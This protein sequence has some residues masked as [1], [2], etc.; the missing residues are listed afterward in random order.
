MNSPL[1]SK[2][3]ND[4][5]EGIDT[6]SQIRIQK[7]QKKG[8]QPA[9]IY[10]SSSSS[11]TFL[12][13]Q[14]QQ[15][16]NEDHKTFSWTKDLFSGPN[17]LV[18]EKSL[19]LEFRWQIWLREFSLHML[20]PFTLPVYIYEMMHARKHLIFKEPWNHLVAQPLVWVV[21]IWFIVER[22]QLEHDG[23]TAV[24]VASVFLCVLFHRAC[25]S[26]K[27]AFLTPEEYKEFHDAEV[28]ISDV[29]LKNMQI[30]S[31]WI[32][33]EVGIVLHEVWVA[34]RQLN[35]DLTSLCFHIHP[36]D[37]KDFA[38]YVD[39]AKSKLDEITHLQISGDM[40]VKIPLVQVAT[41]AYMNAN[42]PCTV[43][44]LLRTASCL[45]FLRAILFGAMRLG[46]NYKYSVLGDS[47]SSAIVSVICAYVI[48][49]FYRLLLLFVY[50][51]VVDTYRRLGVVCDVGDFIRISYEKRISHPRIQLTIIENIS[52]WVGLRRVVLRAGH[53]YRKR[54]ALYLGAGQAAAIVFT[55]ESV[56]L[57]LGSSPP[58][59]LH[60]DARF[61]QSLVDLVIFATPMLL[62]LYLNSLINGRIQNDLESVISHRI[63]HRFRVSEKNEVKRRDR[64][65]SFSVDSD[66]DVSSGFGAFLLKAEYDSACDDLLDTAV[67]A[68]QGMNKR[69]ITVL[70]LRADIRT[71]TSIITFLI[72]LYSFILTRVFVR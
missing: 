67:Q 41:G 50:A 63:G 17:R 47:A 44:Q 68:L 56:V 38:K 45:A 35:I 3:T 36:Q 51:G 37:A 69:P 52:A 31:S 46:K 54:I 12:N 28:E 13:K 49:Y 20:L 8:A 21:L 27:Y 1:A 60:S 53:R 29:W 32:K 24:E 9:V 58:T 42:Q 34:A 70:G 48:F 57:F 7:L 43:T 65:G 22:K 19:W 5:N 40:N 66:T 62:T 6:L 72:S 55:I 11:S 33:P 59:S 4:N 18:V 14:I 30:M 15:D 10:A 71:L 16:T 25:I 23:I 39:V 61:I 64:Q 2:D 26:M